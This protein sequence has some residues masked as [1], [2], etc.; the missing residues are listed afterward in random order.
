MIL[1][2]E[3]RIEGDMSVGISHCVESV[4]LNFPNLDT[5]DDDQ[6]AIIKEFL[7]EFF[8]SGDFGAY[9]MN[10]NDLA[11]EAHEAE[12]AIIQIDEIDAFQKQEAKYPEWD[13]S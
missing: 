5:L 1:K 6:D 10:E 9:A 4:E 3:V 7:A 13:E 12:E 2:Y 11:R 8:D